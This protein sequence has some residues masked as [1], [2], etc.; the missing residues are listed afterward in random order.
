MGHQQ[1]TLSLNGTRWPK[2]IQRRYN[3]FAVLKS[4]DRLKIYSH[5]IVLR[6][7]LGKKRLSVPGRGKNSSQG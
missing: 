2:S 7:I 5:H 3:K 6:Y 1:V 4:I